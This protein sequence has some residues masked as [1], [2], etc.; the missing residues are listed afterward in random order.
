M[1]EEVYQKIASYNHRWLVGEI[2]H[3]FRDGSRDHPVPAFIIDYRGSGTGTSS[4]GYEEMEM[5]ELIEMMYTGREDR[6]ENSHG[7]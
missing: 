6:F 5:D 1:S 4:W 3:R 2:L 7:Y